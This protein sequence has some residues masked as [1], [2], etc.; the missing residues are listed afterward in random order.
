MNIGN[1][2]STPS[3]GAHKLLGR[4]DLRSSM[5]L[6]GGN[7]VLQSRKELAIATTQTTLLQQSNFTKQDFQCITDCE[8]L[9]I[10]VLSLDVICNKNI[11]WIVAIAVF[12]IYRGFSIYHKM[13]DIGDCF[14]LCG[15]LWKCHSG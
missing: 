7:Y 15:S 4:I 12:N 13:Q 10:C 8:T 5:Y 3:T 2:V 14:I 11:V 9:E 6:L 1:G